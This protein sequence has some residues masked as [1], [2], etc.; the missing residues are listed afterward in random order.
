LRRKIRFFFFPLKLQFRGFKCKQLSLSREARKQF[1]RLKE[2]LL[3]KETFSQSKKRMG[4]RKSE[5]K[6]SSTE[7]CFF[8]IFLSLVFLPVFFLERPKFFFLELIILV[9]LIKKKFQ[10]LIY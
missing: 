1:F 2:R 4:K 7:L 10:F 3:F 8:P 9:C 5:E 6:Q